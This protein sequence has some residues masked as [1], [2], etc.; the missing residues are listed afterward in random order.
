MRT[1]MLASLIVALGLTTPGCFVSKKETYIT[2]SSPGSTAAKP[3]N[4]ADCERAGGK[5]KSLL[6]HCDMDDS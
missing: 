4:E 3:T 6:H 2:P 5:W 1:L